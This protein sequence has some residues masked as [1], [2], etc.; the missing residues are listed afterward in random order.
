MPKSVE[1]C[2]KKV[3]PNIKPRNPKQDKES[4]AWAVCMASYQKKKKKAKRRR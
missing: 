1:R 2:V 4:A 3:R